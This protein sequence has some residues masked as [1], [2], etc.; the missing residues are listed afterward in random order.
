MV[1]VVQAAADLLQQ[2]LIPEPLHPA[3]HYR[4]HLWDKHKAERALDSAALLGSTAPA[5]AVTTG[6]LKRM[7][8][9]S[10][11][12]ILAHEV[13]HLRNKDTRVLSMA[14]IIGLDLEKVQVNDVLQSAFDIFSQQLK[15]RGIK[16]VWEIEKDLPRI[17]A[18]A[19]RL[20][21]VF[22]NLLLNA[23]DAIQEK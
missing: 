14:A 22:I 21:Q 15:L 6:L 8:L 17:N 11:A 3:H 13:S 2:V 5:I 10:L 4:V 20:E 16:V 19:G 23:R 12:N 1:D 9:R 18:D 7:S